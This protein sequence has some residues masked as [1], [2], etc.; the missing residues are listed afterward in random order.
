MATKPQDVSGAWLKD[1]SLLRSD[2]YING[3]WAPADSKTTFRVTDPSTGAILADVAD[4][5]LAET[6]RAIEAA[7]SALPAWRAKT[8]AE[9]AGVLRRWYELLLEN[10]AELLTA[11]EHLAQKGARIPPAISEKIGFDCK[12]WRLLRVRELKMTAEA[13]A[14]RVRQTGFPFEFGPMRARERRI[15]HLALKD[16]TSV[17]ATSEGQGP[18]RRVVI[19]PG[20]ASS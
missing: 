2:A 19:Y 11:L 16:E 17:H 3:S 7:D 15:L 5:G 20:P 8:A 18:E 10:Q 9:R 6:K 4:L 13:A 12:D 1:P 14:E